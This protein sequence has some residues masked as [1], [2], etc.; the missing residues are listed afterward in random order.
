MKNLKY[1][2]EK[3]IAWEDGLGR[4]WQ[5]QPVTT[6]RKFVIIALGIYVLLT[7]CVLAYS[8][9]HP[10]EIRVHSIQTPIVPVSKIPIKLDSIYIPK[11]Q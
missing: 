9:Y 2:K 8:Y 7:I 10:S 1:Y 5:N 3:I 6:Q 11:S 4:K